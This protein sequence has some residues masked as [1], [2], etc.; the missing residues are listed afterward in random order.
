MKKI[1]GLSLLILSSSVLAN[2]PI[3]AQTMKL[4]TIND[5][6]RATLCAQ[7][8]KC[9]ELVEVFQAQNGDYYLSDDTPQFAYFPKK[10]GYKLKNRWDFTGYEHRAGEAGVL[11]D[12]N[13]H[14]R[15]APALYPLA[16]GKRAI[17]L[18]KVWSEMYSGGGRH[19]SVADFIQINPD[20]SY[21]L[22]IQ[23]VSFHEGEMIRACFQEEDLQKLHQCH[24]TDDTVLKIRYRDV[25]KPYYEWHL[26]YEQV[27][28]HSSDKTP[29]KRVIRQETVTPFGQLQKNTEK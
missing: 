3:K 10:D 19:S 29:K 25:G 7:L 20:N 2:T 24:D 17:V 9:G 4:L 13:P 26:S 1:I 21:Q 22:A 14:Y 18:Q 15:I 23:A 5:K 11:E 8:L 12:P 28:Q 16:E 27:T 6:T